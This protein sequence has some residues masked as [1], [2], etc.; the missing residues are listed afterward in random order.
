[1]PT[2]TLTRRSF[3]TTAAA[4]GAGLAVPSGLAA[5]AWAQAS[6]PARSVH[7]IVPY[8]AG[9]GTDFFARLVAAS[10]ST[11][12]GQQLVVEN[13]PGAGTQI[14]AEAAAK[15]EPDGY[16]FLLGDTS[17]YASN[18]SLYQKLPYDP[19]KDFA[20]ISLTGRFAIVLLVNTDKLNVNSVQALIDAAKKAPGAIDY[21]SA[22]VGSPFHLAAELFAQSAGIKL[23]HVPYKGAGPALQD[24]AGGQIGMMFVDF[25]TARSQL[26]LKS[27]KAIGVCSPGEF[28][29]L[30]GVPA[31]AA[32]VPGFE[33]WAWQGFAAP[34]KVSPD[35]IA[36]LREAYLKAVND[37]AIKQKLIDA[38]IDPLQSTPQEMAAYVASETT[39]WEKVIKTA[40]I[41][42]D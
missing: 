35:I 19:Q 37:P 27:I 36:K 11:T 32:T 17:T 15:A 21:A 31:V 6:Y 40:G 25:A 23:N 33:A 13:R 7:L 26:N 42:L 8:A 20:P 34:A 28:Y 16:T 14:G 39:K 12:L 9:G 5:P 30:P 22:G 2:E 24:L 10:M 41:K 3:M 4:F 29:G 38:G 18:K 1:M